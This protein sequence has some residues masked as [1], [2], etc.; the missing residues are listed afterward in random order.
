MESQAKFAPE[1]AGQSGVDGYD[2]EIFDLRANLY[3]R[4]IATAEDNLNVRKRPW[5]GLRNI[6]VWRKVMKT[7]WLY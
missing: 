4:Q 2:E 5:S 7:T 3:E 6:P 1:F